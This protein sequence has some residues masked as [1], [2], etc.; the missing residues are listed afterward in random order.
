VLV[1]KNNCVD[2]KNSIAVYPNPVVNTNT[3]SIKLL[4]TVMGKAEIRILNNLGQIVNKQSVVTKVG[5]TQTTVSLNNMTKGIYVIQVL[6]P[7]GESLN[8][9]L[10]K[11]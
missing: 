2:S 6:M 9:K 7:N 8:H 1:V 3:V 4:S 10:I 5:D 11:E